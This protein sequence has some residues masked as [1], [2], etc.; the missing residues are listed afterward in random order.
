MRREKLAGRGVLKVNR[1]L[2]PPL[3]ICDW[4]SFPRQ[5]SGPRY[6]RGYSSCQ[7]GS[8]C[9]SHRLWLLSRCVSTDEMAAG[10]RILVVVNHVW[11]YLEE[12]HHGVIFVNGV[13]AVDGV[14]AHEIAEARE[15]CNIF[16]ALQAGR[17]FSPNLPRPAPRGMGTCCGR[18]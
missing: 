2:F 7:R 4:S 5:T 11:L 10:L 1:A 9:H 17:V 15:R 14:V 8:S 3:Y 12:Q 16:L 6:R 13:V 18:A